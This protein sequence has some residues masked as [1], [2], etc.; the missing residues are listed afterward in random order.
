MIICIIFFL[1]GNLPLPSL[2]RTTAKCQDT[3]TNST[4]KYQPLQQVSAPCCPTAP[5]LCARARS[6]TSGAGSLANW[7][8]KLPPEQ[9][10]AQHRWS[11]NYP[12]FTQIHGSLSSIDV[13]KLQS[14]A[15]HRP[16]HV[17][18]RFLGKP[19]EKVKGRRWSNE[20]LAKCR[21]PGAKRGPKNSQT[22]Q[23]I[24]TQAVQYFSISKVYP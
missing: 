18:T 24:Q 5:E 8:A 20:A 9:P 3:Y 7:P 13:A 21:S 15:I 6:P 12:K 11:Q 2:K 14:R 22:I 10:R 19:S 17:A 16:S 23:T 1:C 4:F